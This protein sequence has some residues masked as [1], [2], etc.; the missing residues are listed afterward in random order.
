MLPNE[1]VMC[2]AKIT[3]VNTHYFKIV[4]C[5]ITSYI[6]SLGKRKRDS[7]CGEG[8]YVCL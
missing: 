3:H 2:N 6:E 8:V 7:V 1:I 4:I 5:A